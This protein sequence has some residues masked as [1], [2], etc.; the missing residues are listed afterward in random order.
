[1]TYISKTVA[2]PRPANSDG[3]ANYLNQKLTEFVGR[4][5][6]LFCV[7]KEVKTTAL[8]YRLDNW[9]LKILVRR[10]Q[11]NEHEKLNYLELPACDLDAVR[12]FF[13]SVFGWKFT[14]YGADYMDSDGGG[15]MVGFYRDSKAALTENGSVLVTFYSDDLESTQKKI[16]KGG[17]TCLLYTSPSP[18]DQRGSRMPSSA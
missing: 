3:T 7:E 15:I 1:M 4:G 6:A 10:A 16:E 18:R 5:G 13:E 17:G 8:R 2:P 14:L 12:A 11:M 9:A